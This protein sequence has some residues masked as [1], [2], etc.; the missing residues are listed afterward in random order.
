MDDG[1]LGVGWT[2]GIE[3]ASAFGSL[4]TSPLVVNGTVYLQDLA[5][6]DMLLVPVGLGARP[7]ILALVLG[8]TGTIPTASPSVA[9]PT[10]APSP[11]PSGNTALQ[12]STPNQGDGRYSVARPMTSRTASEPRSGAGHEVPH[13]FLTRKRPEVQIL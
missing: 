1:P 12:I 4:A 7:M 5:A 13:S 6:G 11:N 9:A 2:Y 8:A 3:G 10:S